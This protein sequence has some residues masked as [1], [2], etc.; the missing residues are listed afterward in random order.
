MTSTIK[1]SDTLFK[2]LQQ[3]AEPF[4]DTPENVI[5]RI[6]QFYL[7]N[8]NIS[9][10]NKNNLIRLKPEEILTNRNKKILEGTKILAAKVNNVKLKKRERGYS[11][12][13]LASLAIVQAQEKNNYSIEKLSKI[14]GFKISTEKPIS[15]K[16]PTYIEEL[17][18]WITRQDASL[19]CIHILK[20]VQI[21]E[22]NFCVRFK[23]KNSTKNTY[24]GK[25]GKI[26]ININ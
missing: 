12:I 16:Q 6:L 26:E 22:I 9:S 5:D 11:W 25:E 10:T 2:K 19:S 23:W 18:V 24:S 17:N 1:I 4:V 3:L 20:L 15:N 13:G 7:K 8:K 14:S 21:S